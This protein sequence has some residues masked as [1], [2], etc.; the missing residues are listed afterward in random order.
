MILFVV[1]VLCAPT[2]GSELPIT[3]VNPSFELPGSGTQIT[4]WSSIDGWSG[5]AGSGTGVEKNEYYSPVDGEW[6]A[7]HAGGEPYTY[8]LTDHTITAG[9]TYT[10]KVWARS[11]NSR[12]TTAA[13]NA[14]VRF[15]YGSTTIT[16]VTQN[17]NPVELQG[18]PQSYTNDDGGNVIIDQGYRMEFAEN[19]FYQLESADPLYDSWYRQVDFD[20]DHNMA[21][22]PIIT[23]QGLKAL[24]SHE[25]RESPTFNKIGLN[26]FSGTPPDYSWGST[27]LVLEHVGDENPA[28][29]DAHAYYDSGNSRLWMSWGGGTCWVSEMDPTDGMLIDHPSNKEFDSHPSWYHTAV[30]YWSGD[31]W[32]GDN[33]WFEGPCLYK[34]NGYWYFLAS[35][36]NLGENY[37]IRGGRGTSP[38]GPYY[39]KDGVG[40]MEWDSGESEYGNSFLLGAEGYQDNPGHPHIWEE[41]GT[42]YLGYDYTIGVEQDVFGIR[43]LY[44]VDDWPTIWTP[45]TVTFNAYDYPAA[46]GQKLGISLRNVGSSSDAAFDYVSLTYTPP[47]PDMDGSGVVNFVDYSLFAAQWMRTDCNDCN[48]ADF[49]AEGNNVD[50]NDL[51][52]FVDNWLRDY[53]LVGYW[54]LD[55]DANDS[56]GYAHDGTVQGGAVWIDDPN[57]GWCLSLDGDDDYVELGTINGTDELALAGSNFTICS[58]IKPNLT[59]DSYQRIVDKSDGGIGANGYSFHV[60]TNGKIT[61]HVASNNFRSDG[62]VITAGIWQHVAVTGDGSDYQF[63]VDGLPVSGSFVGGSY[64]SPP[65]VNT[66]MRIGTWNHSTGR[67]FNGS[68]DEVRIY[69]K[70]LNQQQIEA[71]AG[72]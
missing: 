54:K 43:I 7:F 1:L 46:I 8:Q 18:A 9:K 16:S 24:Y 58:W 15:Y 61:I 41:S 45:I 55:G 29:M 39:D 50:Y 23:A 17:V 65:S 70:A 37:S 32:T 42:F 25:G 56:S 4:N 28:P 57:R 44:W 36:G 34:H 63:Y 30:A 11:T 2:Q 35:Y 21:V 12:G 40:L 20:Y 59:G 22:G 27:N 71:L 48:G 62:S 69:D 51:A 31:E 5:S 47:T 68:I 64:N 67:E 13:T 6:Y 53:S 38:T 19:I 66:N 52:L 33:E 26:T 72:M 3:I 60:H 10:L 14:E 49:T